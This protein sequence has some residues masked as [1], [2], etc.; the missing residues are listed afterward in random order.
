[1]IEECTFKDV[2]IWNMN[3]MRAGSPMYKRLVESLQCDVAELWK[4]DQ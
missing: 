2:S 4:D 3:E 1:M